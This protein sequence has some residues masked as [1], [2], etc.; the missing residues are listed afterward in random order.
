MVKKLCISV[1]TSLMATL[2]SSANFNSPDFAFPATVIADANAVL[3]DTSPQDSG[4]TRL[5]A[6][7][8]I[9][10]A[11]SDIGSDAQF[12][13][14]A[15]I[16]S[17]AQ[18]ETRANVRGLM[19]LLQA[20]VVNDIYESA[21]YR[22]N[23]VTPVTP[24]PDD[25]REW[26]GTDFKTEINRL[27]AMASDCLSA[28]YTEPLADYSDV[29]TC[30]SLGRDYFPYLRDFLW[31]QQVD[32]DYKGSENLVRNA[33]LLSPEGSAEWAWWT[34]G[35][36]HAR[37]VELNQ[38]KSLYT[39]AGTDAA[40]I[41]VLVNWL[42]M[43]ST[44]AEEYE[45]YTVAMSFLKTAPKSALT[46]M[47]SGK[48][49][50]YL[51][52]YLE[53]KFRTVV[54]PGQ[55][56][57]FNLEHN[58]SKTVGFTVHE[59]EDCDD[60]PV[61]E[62]T[63][64][65]DS[66]LFNKAETIKH[67]F[68]KPGVYYVKSK[69]NGKP[70][71]NEQA[72]LV[73][74][75]LVRYIR[76]RDKDLW[77]VTDTR[78][79]A[80]V[81]GIHLSLGEGIAEGVS[82]SNGFAYLS[83]VG[84]GSYEVTVTL[85]DGSEIQFPETVYIDEKYKEEEDN[86]SYRGNVFFSR[87]LYRPGE[88]AECAA[89]VTKVG[90]SEAN[91]LADT[92]VEFQWENASGEVI[93]TDTV[94]T[95][96][97]GRATSRLE[98][99]TAA[100]AGRYC[101]TV[102]DVESRR[103]IGYASVM[104]SE[105]KRPVFELVDVTMKQ[106]GDSITVSGRAERFTGAAV[107]G[108]RVEANLLQERWWVPEDIDIKLYAVTDRQGRFAVTFPADGLTD[109]NQVEVSVRCVAPSGDVAESKSDFIYRPEAV[110]NFKDTNFD[111]SEPFKVAVGLDYGLR[112]PF[113]PIVNWKLLKDQKE[114]ASGSSQLEKDGMIV[115]WTKI[116]AGEYDLY[117]TADGCAYYNIGV[118]LYNVK[119]NLVPDNYVAIIPETTVTAS[120]SKSADVKI[121][122]PARSYA[123]IIGTDNDGRTDVRVE[124]LNKGFSNLSL[125]AD[126]RGDKYYTIVIVRGSSFKYYNVIV[127]AIEPD[128]RVWLRGESWR[129]KIVPGTPQRW[130]LRFEDAQQQ[131]VSGAMIATMFNRALESYVDNRWSDVSK[132][133]TLFQR[134][135]EYR[136]NSLWDGRGNLIEVIDKPSGNFGISTPVFKYLSHSIN[137]RM[138]VYSSNMMAKSVM[139]DSHSKLQGVVEV[140][141]VEEE[142]AYDGAAPAAAGATTAVEKP[143][144]R[145]AEVLQ[146]FWKPNLTI[147]S[148]GVA[149]IEFEMPDA[150]G[151]WQFNATA[152]SLSGRS[153]KMTAT[154]ES[155]K[156]VTI[157]SNAPRF[158]RAGDT[159]DI[160][161]T[162]INRTDEVVTATVVLEAFDIATGKVIES[163]TQQISLA[164]AGQQ[165]VSLPVKVDA[166]LP[167]VGF[168]CYASAAEFKDG[169]QTSI[170]VLASS[171]K[172][173]DS[174]IFYMDD[175]KR[176]VKVTIPADT[177]GEGFATVQ[178]CANP[179]WDVVKALPALY[180]FA[181]KTATGAV[182]SLFGSM[183]AKGIAQD[184]PE[185]A[186]A[187]KVW[188]ENPADSALVSPLKKNEDLKMITLGA[189]PFIG[190]ADYMT[191]QMQRLSLTLD[192]EES[193][194]VA[195][196]AVAALE[197]LQMADGGF[198]WLEWNP[199]SSLFITDYVLQLIG[200]LNR[201][202]YND[203]RTD[204]IA[205]RAFRYIDANVK[206]MSTRQL[207]YLY[208]L[209]P[210]RM[211]SDSVRVA[212][213]NGVKDIIMNWRNDGATF[214]A[215]DAMILN[216]A[217]H[218]KEATTILESLMQFAVK[219]PTL[220][221]EIPSVHIV[222]A[223]AQILE[224]FAT[225]MPESKYIDGLRKWLVLKTQ[226]T[227]DLG[228]WNPTELIAAMM[229][230]GT[231]WTSLND[232]STT[233]KIDGAPLTPSRIEYATGT[234]SMRLPSSTAPRLLEISRDIASDVPAYGSVMTVGEQSLDSIAASDCAELAISK[235]LLVR[236]GD[237]WVDT[238]TFT[239]GQTVKVQLMLRADRELEYVTVSDG[240]P[241]GFEPA[242]QMPGFYSGAGL[243]A[244]RANDLTAT[245][246]FIGY[247]PKGVHYLEYE[248][249]AGSEGSFI[250]G[251]VT[252]QSQYAPE[253]T[254]RSGARHITVSENR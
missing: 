162:V 71:W 226:T 8:Q 218:R 100:M 243:W 31:A 55:D 1:I 92:K 254:A 47:L 48:L 37:I 156:P 123:Y 151:S 65:T 75:V 181:P 190:A 175:A 99:T 128:K 118:V 236:D 39:K 220:G 135:Y 29:I 234:F 98:L 116:P 59:D 7:L 144:L 180:D 150:I 120:P 253:F 89:V 185:A 146:I 15:L 88:M 213:D 43:A 230:T 227:D 121:G 105:Y 199:K 177:S 194:K 16:D 35:G 193:S 229:A 170:P 17:V 189:T 76:G 208:S 2:G 30:D 54:A 198:S 173:I 209:F 94:A 172:A 67:S 195:D 168:R 90:Y 12:E 25:I 124:K 81:S 216:S 107:P 127:K 251:V 222:D 178:F 14:P 231:R 63:I 179:M 50:G 133:F 26:S 191:R 49:N 93:A 186:E 45:A 58:F 69:I 145:N 159:F 5:A 46:E 201:L 68:S 166:S 137:T 164:A 111:C 219:S 238:D 132:L 138:A 97:Y 113:Y 247:L 182:N 4:C 130:R 147:D 9:V 73:S 95:D 143:T 155:S 19:Y 53:I 205:T 34:L 102:N 112:A 84:R 108:A 6:L 217:G 204:T 211:P 228:A 11:T 141:S 221:L 224:A 18:T 122:V 153:A 129:D 161:A 242:E 52:P 252:V 114:I 10:R 57:V 197:R 136:V 237:T 87:P 131:P 80:P 142:V 20:R 244:Y 212:I 110:F 188:Y 233:I 85:P 72:L 139:T 126:S 64:K 250:S 103:Y 28:Y 245:N 239:M 117:V 40:K 174:E 3:A 202:G 169:E 51:K 38:L 154:L 109:A 106:S 241:A 77:L 60:D 42:G 140:A 215:I 56:V 157:E 27:S 210:D 235:R 36:T 101:V 96:K 249:I 148:A 248:A 200:R 13:L 152:W 61:Y 125:L 21:Q 187:V 74:P 22:Y 214:K 184:F 62:A 176:T 160:P 165:Q 83:V 246:F 183:I 23:R 78:T 232:L 24:R 206:L 171:V 223:Y 79:G 203:A 192:P 240:R 115:D 70:G 149:E 44:S 33:A 134:N 167:M 32:L 207:A 196:V 66:T 163:D 119:R 86:E 82:D 91:I 158:V 104:V 41:L 225:V